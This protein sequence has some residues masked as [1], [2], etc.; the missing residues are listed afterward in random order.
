MNHRVRILRKKLSKMRPSRCEVRNRIAYVIDHRNHIGSGLRLILFPIRQRLMH[1]KDRLVALT[2]QLIEEW[3]R[4]SKQS[5][6]RFLM[7]APHRHD[8]VR[9]IK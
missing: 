5:L 4:Q 2:T 8:T 9:L 1:I 3:D 7:V 6:H